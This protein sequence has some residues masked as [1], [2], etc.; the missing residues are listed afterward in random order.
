[1][2]IPET[3]ALL[4]WVIGTAADTQFGTPAYSVRLDSQPLPKIHFYEAGQ[5]LQHRHNH[6]TPPSPV[7]P[8]F[9]P[10][11]ADHFDRPIIVPDSV[12]G[13]DPYPACCGV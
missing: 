1:M 12:T 11:Y 6:N 3:A 8:G 7:V 9:Y 4:G 2:E 13:W 5:A 10:G